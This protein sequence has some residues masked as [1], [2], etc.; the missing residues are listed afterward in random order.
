M[1]ADFLSCTWVFNPL[2]NRLVF[3][4]SSIISCR[5]PRL[6]DA[7]TTSSYRRRISEPSCLPLITLSCVT[8]RC[9]C[10]D[11]N[12]K[13]EKLKEEEEEKKK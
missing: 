1:E 12:I 4:C 7:E 10:L 3:F 11:Y 8:H 5:F 9:P 2:V 13:I 6:L